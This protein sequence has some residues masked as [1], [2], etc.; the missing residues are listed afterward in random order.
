MYCSL[1]SVENCVNDVTCPSGRLTNQSSAVPVSVLINILQCIA[2]E[3]PVSIICVWK[4]VR[5]PFGSSTPVKVA[6]GPTNVAGITASMIACE[7]GIGKALGGVAG[8]CSSTARPLPLANSC[9]VLRFWLAM[10]PNLTVYVL[11][12]FLMP[13]PFLEGRASFP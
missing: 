6:L 12:P 13:P 8:S 4:V 5:W 10:Q 9:A 2:S 3:P 11:D 7:N 1:N